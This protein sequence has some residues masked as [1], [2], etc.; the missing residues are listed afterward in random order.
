MKGLEPL[1]AQFSCLKVLAAREPVTSAT[2]SRL[3][4]VPGLQATDTL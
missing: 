2:G 1:E 3:Q 4:A